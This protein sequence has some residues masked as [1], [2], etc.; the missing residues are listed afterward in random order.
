MKTL[1][2]PKSDTAFFMV[3][4]GVVV[5]AAV[6]VIVVVVSFSSCRRRRRCCCCRHR[7]SSPSSQLL[8]RSFGG[9]PLPGDG[10]GAVG[11]CDAILVNAYNITA[12]VTVSVGVGLCVTADFCSCPLHFNR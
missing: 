5:A 7:P 11:R 8:F 4:V 10:V 9:W 12:V 2:R 1:R 6:I 3:V